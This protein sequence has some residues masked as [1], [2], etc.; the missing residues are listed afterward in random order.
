MTI[1][2]RI[3]PGKVQTSTPWLDLRSLQDSR[4]LLLVIGSCFVSF[5]LFTPFCYIVSYATAHGVDP[6]T[7]FYV[8]AM[9]NLA[10][11]FGRIAPAHFADAFGRFALLVP[12]AFLAGASS[13]I[14]WS[15]A[16]TLTQLMAYAALY[17]LSSGAFNALIVPCIAQISD[18]REI[19]MR[20]GLLYSIISFP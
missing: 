14:L 6:T 3:A 11:V 1:T 12:C 18:I 20:I 19:G 16:Q 9:L 4:F 7:S 17:G 15:T 5:G 10:S 13:L 2:S 8:L